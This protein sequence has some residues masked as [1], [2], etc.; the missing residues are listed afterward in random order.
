[1]NQ[2]EELTIQNQENYQLY[3]NRMNQSY[4]V[5]SKH[6]IPFYT[7]GAKNILDVGCAD[8]TLIK[9]IKEINPEKRVIGIDLNQNA[10]DRAVAAGLEVYHMSLEE[11]HSLNIGFDCIIFSSVLHE[12]SS[13]ASANRFT[14]LPIAEALRSAYSLLNHN[15][16]IVIRDGLKEDFH[17]TECC[18]MKFTNPD[19]EK[20]FNR[21]IEEYKYP[22]FDYRM[23]HHYNGFTCDKDVAQEFLA[24]WTWGE[25][26]WNREINEKFCILTESKWMSVIRN[27][28]FDVISFF[29]SKEEYPKFLTPKVKL[30]AEDG[31]DWFP[32]MTC[33]IVA[34]KVN[35]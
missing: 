6:F 27:A 19:N 16:I 3:L 26:S 32:Y 10:V 33:T 15:G 2:L 18:T 30:Y 14:A 1:M 35:N 25:E 28:G 12:I 4:A 24:T 20:W 21:F 8:G 23:I 9:A 13:Y 22:F 7:L 31:K 29:K 34:K 5:S 11:V 17:Y